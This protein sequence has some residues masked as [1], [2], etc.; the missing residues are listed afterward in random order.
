MSKILTPE[1]YY[2]QTT[3]QIPILDGGGRAIYSGE[4]VSEYAE[5]ILSKQPSKDIILPEYKNDDPI[6]D[7]IIASYYAKKNEGWNAAIDEVKRLNGIQ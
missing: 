3:D 7:N 5:Y 1:D 2:I 4:F 6:E